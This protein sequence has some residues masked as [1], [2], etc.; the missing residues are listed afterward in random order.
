METEVDFHPSP[1]AQGHRLAASGMRIVLIA[2][3]VMRIECST[4]YAWIARR[5]DIF[6]NRV[7]RCG[8][9]ARRLCACLSLPLVMLPQ[10]VHAQ[11]TRSGWVPHV[12]RAPA[13]FGGWVGAAHRVATRACAIG[14]AGRCGVR[15]MAGSVYPRDG[16]HRR[17]GWRARSGVVPGWV[18]GGARSPTVAEEG[19]HRH[20]LIRFS[21]IRRPCVRELAVHGGRL[22]ECR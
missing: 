22:G 13:R 5:C 21:R 20:S 1:L 11:L 15:Y 4:Y 18:C 3:L 2:T 10:G 8:S 7:H 19:A 17:S 6:P 14:A 16:V 9:N 12:P